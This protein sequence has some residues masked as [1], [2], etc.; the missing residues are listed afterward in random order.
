METPPY[1]APL[2]VSVIRIAR[3]SR[4]R[5]E[6]MPAV[7]KYR[8]LPRT[9]DHSI[10]DIPSSIP[11][12]FPDIPY[13]KSFVRQY[14]PLTSYFISPAFGEGSLSS[15]SIQPPIIHRSVSL[16]PFQSLD[17]NHRIPTNDNCPNRN[18]LTRAFLFISLVE[19]NI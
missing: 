10:S 19:N 13:S 15:L 16:Q 9:C 6:M 7:L 3:E 1:T 4:A 18:S 14:L 8:N 12:Y 5:S 11:P 17:H 2:P